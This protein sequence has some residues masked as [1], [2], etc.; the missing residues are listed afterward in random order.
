MSTGAAPGPRPRRRPSHSVTALDR[1]AIT[2]WAASPDRLASVLP[3]GFVPEVFELDDGTP[4]AL[5]SAVTFLDRDFR[6]RGAPFIRLSCGQVNHRA[7]VRYEDE[8]GVWFV[9][10]SLDSALTT[11]PRLVWRM[12][13]H[14]ERISIDA[15]WHGGRCTSMHAKVDGAWGALSIELGGEPAVPPPASLRSPL[16]TDPFVGWYPRLGGGVGRY[17]VWHEPI[18]LQAV[19]VRRGWAR[20]FEALGV[21]D[22]GQ[23]P[24]GALVAPTCDFDVHTPPHRVQPL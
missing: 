12:P 8:P 19:S 2:T 11:M 20:P 4:T 16:H 23:A 1:F 3:A 22:A 6:F 21:L 13:W 24:L 7:Y 18:E 10:T 14:R 17:T 9:G 15:E 5:V